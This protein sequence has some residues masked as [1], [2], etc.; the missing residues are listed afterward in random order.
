[1]SGSFP[2]PDTI[3]GCIV[4]GAVVGGVLAEASARFKKRD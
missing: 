3:I 4:T 2:G 1:M